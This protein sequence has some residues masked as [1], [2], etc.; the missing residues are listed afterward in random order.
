MNH[1]SPITELLNYAVTHLVWI[2]ITSAQDWDD[3]LRLLPSSHVLQSW[4]W[5]EFKARWG[6][7]AERWLLRAVD[8]RPRAAVQLL[9]RR[10]G[11]VPLCVLYAPKGPV[12]FD[13]A[14]YEAA[15]GH[16]EQRAHHHRAVWA[17][18]DGDLSPPPD[19]GVGVGGGP[20]GRDI[21]AKL[22]QRRWHQSPSQ[23]QFRNTG[24]SYLHNDEAMLA[25][26]KPKTRYNLRLAEKRGVT[27]RVA[28]P[29]NDA[30]AQLLYAMYAETAQRD[31][32]GIRE[33]PYY[34]D[35]WKSMQTT[36]FIAE[37]DGEPLGG[38]VLFI[39]AQRAWY[40][41]GMSR[42][43]GREHM[44]NYLLQWV[45][46]RWAR[47]HG[48]TTYD[49]WGAPEREDDESDSMAGVWRFKQ[50]FGAHY[51]EGTGAWDFAPVPLLYDLYVKLGPKLI[52]S[53]FGS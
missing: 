7:Q 46:M 2:Q 5:G 22:T 48:C 9:K 35:A 53:G 31:G 11:R 38:I 17:K 29:I 6:W 47:D 3:A 19:G 40:F 16:I 36:G 8:G 52:R 12:A 43:A 15:L 34:F 10:M 18:V 26:M 37:K 14:S 23:I 39:F 30:D 50:G 32:F 27:V 44:P 20:N 4:A 41:Y 24:L 45:A 28:S 13:V 49:W 51:V 21:R 25:A 33:A 42:N 1:E